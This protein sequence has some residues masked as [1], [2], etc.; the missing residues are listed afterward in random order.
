MA[1]KYINKLQGKRIVI[2]GGTSGIGFATAEASIE[3]GAI[4]VLASSQQ[5]KV[6]QAVHRIQT[7]YP[8]A[9]DRISGKTLDLAASDVEDQVTSL[10]DF[11]SDS[12]TSKLDHVVDTAGGTF[13]QIPLS[14]ITPEKVQDVL[15][16][17]LTGGLIVAKIAMRYLNVSPESSLTVT[18]GVSDLKPTQGWAIM[19]PVGSARKGMM[20]ALA[21]DMKPIRVN[22]VCPGATKTELFDRFAADRLEEIMASYRAK[23]LTGTIGTPEDL[24]ECYLSAMKNAFMTGVEIYADGGYLLC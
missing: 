24:A 18:S 7:S 4:V 3:Y 14:E 5:S 8:E 2:I 9:K 6:D 1:P 10:F 16:V 20:R 13:R 11:A 22:C 19:A 17:R 15:Q 12:G 23:T 21:Q